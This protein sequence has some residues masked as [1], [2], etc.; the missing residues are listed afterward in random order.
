MI[1]NED[2]KLFKLRVLKAASLLL[3]RDYFANGMIVGVDMNPCHVNDKSGRIRIFQGL[4]QNTA[5]LDRIRRETPP[6][7]FD[8]IIDDA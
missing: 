2:V 7:G 6:N 5:L 3:W 8:V 1:V 4:Q